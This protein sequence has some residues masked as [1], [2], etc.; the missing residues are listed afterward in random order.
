MIKKFL[1]LAALTL[2]ISSA[3]AAPVPG[4]SNDATF[5]T[6]PASIPTAN[7]ELI[8]Y[9][10]I[11]V[12]LKDSAVS[13][14]KAWNVLYSTKSTGPEAGTLKDEVATGTVFVPNGT[15]K[16]V[17]LYAVGTHGLGA[18]CAAS[19]QLA[20]GTDYE[21]ANIAAA[22]KAGYAVLVT[23][24]VGYTS[25]KRPRYMAGA[26][27]GRNVLDI[28]KAATQIPGVG[29]S[30]SAKT[31][32]W[33]F[34]QGGQAASW[35]AEL[36]PT[37]A[38]HI[39]L[40][41][42]AAGGI[43]G[44]FFDT[45]RYLNARNGASFLLSTVL[46][47]N[48]EYGQTRIPVNLI[49]NPT[50]AAQVDELRG[51]CVFEALFDYQ[52]DDIAEYTKEGYD[53]EVLLT[54]L[55]GVTLTLSEQQLGKTKVNVPVY[56]YH[57]VAD[58]FIPLQQAFDLKKRW[59]ALG[60]T[61]K[62]DAY[63]SEHIAT[64]FQG[65]TSSLAWIDD[66][67]AG[68]A[69]PNTCS[70]TTAPVATP[71]DNTKGIKVALKQ[72]PLAAN[73]VVKGL[74]QTVVLPKESSFSAATDI[75]EKTL[76]GTL[77]VPDFKQS[78]KILGIGAQVGMKIAPI[79]DT[80]GTVSLDRAGQ[81]TITGTAKTDITVTSVWGIP[82]GQ[83]KTQTPVEFPLN[84]KGPVSGL[85]NGLSFTGTTTFPPIKGCIISAIISALMSGSGQQYSFVVT[86]P[87][88]KAN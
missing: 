85:G 9:R 64:Q 58:Q 31:A 5:Y 13:N 59:C 56:Q 29:I 25:G 18:Q 36:H 62:F 52:N 49:I 78:L 83:C 15:A 54:G 43:P 57:G 84:Y 20:A 88:P 77:N 60:S 35:A 72:W 23:D 27:Q 38:P 24:Y 8:T 47:L 45:A 50:G 68:K 21:N 55:P 44:E 46:G 26:S 63:P 65:A 10:P 75:T 11:A 69:A 42:V 14:A 34:S 16:G 32:I 66:R 74:N 3:Y 7:G 53:M 6:T 33:G 39:N 79:G 4:S 61:V 17:I 67:F 82:F 22:L 1:P 28:F 37:Y 48:E 41:G 80:V 86:P 2:A 12:N 73:V 40:V 70:T 30:A 71:E 81:L 51:K 19:K 87:A 76:R